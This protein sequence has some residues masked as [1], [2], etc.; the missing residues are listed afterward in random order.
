MAP[1]IKKKTFLTAKRKAG[2]EDFANVKAKVGRAA[3]PLF[4]PFRGLWVIL[5]IVSWRILAH[6]FNGAGRVAGERVCEIT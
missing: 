5:K 6:G 4:L 1:T 3:A 2:S